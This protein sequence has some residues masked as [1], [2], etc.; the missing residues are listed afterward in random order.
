MK[1]IIMTN[2]AALLRRLTNVQL[3]RRRVPQWQIHTLF[4]LLIVLSWLVGAAYTRSQ[5]VD[6]TALQQPIEQPIEQPVA[7]VAATPEPIKEKPIIEVWAEY[8]A[9]LLYG[10]RFNSEDDLY[11]VIWV[12]ISRV[13]SPLY[14]DDFIEVCQQPQQ[15]MGYS[16]D[17]PVVENLYDI[18]YAAIEAWQS[19]GRRP[20]SS[21][22]LWF[23]W[24]SDEI[25]FRTN[26]EETKS[27]Q[28]WRNP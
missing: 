25:V 28:Y 17:N 14:S 16:D 1:T 23:T 13:E 9:K 19:D 20:F 6:Y 11:C 18:A 12:V 3:H 4:S 26:F 2:A 21:D 10:Y 15:W 22:F 27:C 8:G 7:V 24:S 5:L